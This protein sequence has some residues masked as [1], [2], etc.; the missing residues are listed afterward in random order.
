MGLAVL[1]ALTVRSLAE[2]WFSRL[3]TIPDSMPLNYLY[4]FG[5]AKQAIIKNL[6][7]N[8]ASLIMPLIF[9]SLTAITLL[10]LI[11]SQ[12][13]TTA[14]IAIPVL[15]VTDIF[16]A[17]RRMYDNPSTELLYGSAGRPEMVFLRSRKFDAEHYRIFPVDFDTESITR[18][19]STYHLATVYPYPLVNMFSSSPVIN[20]YGPF[21]LKR[22]PEAVLLPDSLP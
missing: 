21:W 8:S 19:T 15:I 14:L 18:L 17:S 20:D 16:C 1:V 11:R 13:R 4:T 9:L 5:A 3:F 6:S 2:G 22:W 12:L 7:W 10:F